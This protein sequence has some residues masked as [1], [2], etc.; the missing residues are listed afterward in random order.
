MKTLSAFVFF[1]VTSVASLAFWGYEE[2]VPNGA[3]NSC[4]TCHYSGAFADDFREA[5]G[6]WTAALAALDS[7]G[8]GASNGAELGDPFGS[9][10]VGRP[11]PGDPFRVTNPDDGED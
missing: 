5:G 4:N 2:F 9:W 3:V 1:I 7:N 8:D 6:Q 11:D 10:A